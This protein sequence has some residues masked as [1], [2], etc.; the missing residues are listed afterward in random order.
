MSAAASITSLMPGTPQAVAHIF[1]HMASMPTS[2]LSPLPSTSVCSPPGCPVSHPPAALPLVALPD[3]DQCDPLPS[4]LPSHWIRALPPPLRHQVRRL[5]VKGDGS[6]ADGAIVQAVEQS[7]YLDS[8]PLSQS[9][10]PNTRSTATFRQREVGAAMAEWT[11]EDWVSKMPELCREDEWQECCRV[12]ATNASSRPARSP[13][14]ELDFFRHTLGLPT[15]PVGRAYLHAAAGALQQGILVLTTD[16]RYRGPAAQQLDDFGTEQYD[17][18]IVLFFSVGPPKPGSRGDGHYETVCLSPPGEDVVHTVFERQH[19]L[20]CGLRAWAASHADERTLEHERVQRFCFPAICMQP[21]ERFNGPLTPTVAAQQ[22]SAVGDSAQSETRPRRLRNLPA[23]L[24]DDDG[25]GGGDDR[26]GWPVLPR[27]PAA[28][29]SLSVALDVA[30]SPA[31]D[32]AIVAGGE[33]PPRRARD[34][35]S[36]HA[37]ATALPAAAAA[38]APPSDRPAVLGEL[39]RRNLQAWVRERSRRGRLASRV[40]LSAVPMWTARCRTVLLGLAG[41]L[42]ERPMNEPKVVTWLC[43]LWMLP[44]EVFTV[45]GRTRGGKAGRKSRHHRIH[46]ALSDATLLSRLAA[47][48]EG[49]AETPTQHPSSPACEAGSA[50]VENAAVESLPSLSVLSPLPQSVEADAACHSAAVPADGRGAAPRAPTDSSIALRV[51]HLFRLGHVQR[52][53]RSLVSTTGKADLDQPAER[54]ALRALHPPCPGELPPCPSD[55]PE[56]VVDPSWMADEMLRSDT[57]A[58]PGPSGYGSNFMQV[59]AADAACVSAMAVLIGHIVNDQLPATV[60]SLLNTCVLVSLEKDGGGRRP[61]AMGDMFYRMAARF[62]LSLVLEPAQRALR[63]HQFAVGVEDGCTQVV[64]SLQHLLSLPPAPAPPPPRPPHQ[65]AFSSPRPAPQPA[66]PTARPLACLS[67]DV[68]NAFNSIDRAALLRA[69]YG[70]VE[71]A[72]CWRMVSFG[73][74]HPSLLLMPCGAEVSEAEAFIESSNGVR[75]GDPLAALLFA[76]A[77]HGVYEQV[78]RLC[79]SGCFAYSDDSHGVGWLEEC[80]RAWEALPALLEPLGLHLNA[81][82]C[83]LTCFHTDALQ[84]ARDVAALDAFRAA[85]VTVNTSTLKVLGCVVGASDAVIAR[86]LRQRPSLRADQ[87]V[88]FRR[89]PLLRKPTGYLALTQLTG[90]VLTNRLRAMSP[91]STESQAVEYDQQVLRVAHDLAGIGEADGDR[92]D[93]QLRLPTRLCGLGLLSAERIA[94][95]AFL[96]GAECTLR[97]SPAFSAVWSA[98]AELEPAWPITQGI[99]DALGRVA[100]V[101]AALV[102]RC[103]PQV[104]AAVGAS[105]LPPGAATFVAHF[106]ALPP[107]PIQSA[108][109]HRITTLS[110][111]ARMKAA[112]E[113]GAQAEA[114]VARL[115]ALQEKESS[116]WLRVLPVDA[117]LRLSD[118]Q[119]QT[120][121]QLRLGMPRAPHGTAASHCEH[122]RA[123]A[124]DGW[125]PLVCIT[126]SGPAINAR[127]HAVV[128]LLADAAAVLKVPARVEPYNLCDDDDSR[129]DIQ[130]DLPEYSLLVDV[131]ISHPCAGRWRT[132]TAARGVEAVGDARCAEKD[133]S[134]G[135]MA[136]ALDVR[137]A[138]FVLYSY[139]GFHKSALSVIEQLGAAHDPAVALVS[140][141]TWKQE[142]KDRIAVCVQQ[143]TA[144]IMIEDARR[145]RAAGV[146]GS[147][148]RARRSGAKRHRLPLSV[149]PPRRPVAAQQHCGT[150]VRAVSLSAPL[151][152]SPLASCPAGPDGQ[153]ADGEQ[154]ASMLVCMSPAPPMSAM[155]KDVFVPG[156]PGMEP[157]SPEAVRADVDAAGCTR[158]L[159]A[160]CIS[161]V[162]GAVD[163]DARVEVGGGTG[164]AGATVPLVAGGLVCG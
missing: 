127:H 45:P 122:Q 138:P 107:S 55:A 33:T 116:R 15:H 3:C 43:V 66:D 126:R 73:Y 125:H 104:A 137:F 108:I 142:L 64:Q 70:S 51:E 80:W 153:S 161:R 154:S 128:R 8:L 14:R 4:S 69:V 52:A 12:G 111:S 16:H 132:T 65:F 109:I 78:A 103:E 56:L 19:P 1:E 7:E 163:R 86:E 102:A 113:G 123:A 68:A 58:T 2:P 89:L 151:L 97:F 119:W 120:A 101:E 48:A 74:G 50:W 148:R 26:D 140:L 11:A 28:V 134:Y 99:T 36:R 62:A 87:R 90:T 106:K 13:T 39:A 49:G 147:R 24:R 30:A 95:A 92:Y 152:V 118:L 145:A 98:T 100:A 162:C 94:P 46:H 59:L 164:A 156:T 150:G 105:I 41:A 114:E 35:A 47:R 149:L 31:T 83:E 79:R 60:R 37:A 21:G 40:H 75:Q 44:Q 5:P 32:P 96:A 53:M 115:R 143:H 159:S 57:G 157:E 133:S 29:R 20:L 22:S 71:L 18:S 17:S 160:L 141:G 27:R 93:E 85:G 129:P 25:P 9:L 146:V 112:G 82:K 155:S 6:C 81:A 77:M 38:R 135:P 54:D 88:A 76:L 121:V 124:T 136:K 131:T 67:I 144:N 23:R 42:Q 10:R 130:L 72:A 117:G 139:G 63:P 34:R 91:A 84:H 158:A 110:H 61:V